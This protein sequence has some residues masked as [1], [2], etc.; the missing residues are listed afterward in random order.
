MVRAAYAFMKC[1]IIWL[2]M[3]WPHIQHQAVLSLKRWFTIDKNPLKY[4]DHSLKLKVIDLSSVLSRSSWSRG[5]WVLIYAIRL[6]ATEFLISKCSGQTGGG[7][8]SLSSFSLFRYFLIYSEWSKHCLPIDYHIHVWQVSP[9]L[10]AV[11]PAKY[12]CAKNMGSVGLV[13]FH[14]KLLTPRCECITTMDLPHR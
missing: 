5:S 4:H 1:V 3:W 14:R 8:V 12:E 13:C 7:R 6:S 10:T 2:V 9:C 11:K